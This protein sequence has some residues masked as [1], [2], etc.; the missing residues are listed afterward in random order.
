MASTDNRTS[1]SR[2]R[3]ATPTSRSPTTTP[4]RSACTNG[5]LVPGVYTVMDK[6]NP[7]IMDSSTFGFA[8]QL[9]PRLSRDHSLR[10]PDQHRR[11]LPPPA[12]RH[13]MGAGQHHHLT[14]LPESQ[15]RER[16]MVLGFSMPGD[17]V[18]GATPAANPYSSRRTATGAFHG[19]SG[20]TEASCPEP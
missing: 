5:K 9:P 2:S 12:Q 7:V 14:R 20:D 19:T 3:S 8:D 11:H 16:E 17:V 4:S 13:C 1:T 18:E 6:A 10:H 15:R